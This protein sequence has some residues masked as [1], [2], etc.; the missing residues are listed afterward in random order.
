[1]KPEISAIS[2]TLLLVAAAAAAA[3]TVTLTGSIHAA[4]AE[5]TINAHALFFHCGTSYAT[6]LLTRANA[7]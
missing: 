1:M 7:T 2:Q 4:S 6:E 5:T 3:V